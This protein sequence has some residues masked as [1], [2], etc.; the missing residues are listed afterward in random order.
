MERRGLFITFEGIDGCGKS[1]QAKMLADYLFNLNKYNHVLKT[2]EP[3]KCQDIRKILQADSNPYSQGEKLARLFVKDRKE[4][5]E[6]IIRPSLHQG[7][8]VILDRYDC[9]T[10][11]YQQTQG[12]P[13]KKLLDMHKGLIIPDVTFI[14]DVPAELAV[15]RIK[16]D[17]I[18]QE[19]QKF[20]KNLEFMQELRTNYLDI[21]NKIPN[22]N[23]IIIDARSGIDEIFE[24][25]VKSY[26]E[27]LRKY[28]AI[29][30][31]K[32]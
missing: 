14:I 21:P 17:S 6:K 26:F 11:A 27:N 20:E 16:K 18:R 13:F 1:T 4:H 5:L 28:L 19:E 2:R 29:V 25:Q 9:S 10:L 23:F 7:I 24:G 30:A 15:K 3:Y 8:H 12:V 32:D 31:K 22:R